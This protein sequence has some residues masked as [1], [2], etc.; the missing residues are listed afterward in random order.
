[1]SSF[2]ILTS[3]LQNPVSYPYLKNA[4]ITPVFKTGDRNSMD[5]Y[6]PFSILPNISKIFERF[7]FS[8]ILQFDGSNFVFA[9][10]TAHNIVY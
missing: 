5:N 8:T 3:L 4:R 6:R 10:V 9:E 2:W 7:L 1:M